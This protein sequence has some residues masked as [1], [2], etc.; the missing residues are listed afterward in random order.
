ML[1]EGVSKH[2]IVTGGTRGIGFSIASA[3][4]SDGYTVLATGVSEAEVEACNAPDGVATAVLDVTDG[5][6]VSALVD[7]CPRIDALV[8]CAGVILREGREFDPDA[9]AKV[10]DINLT[11]TMRMCVAAKD[12]LTAAAA[13]HGIAAIV[14]TASMLSFFGSAFVP[15]YSASKG[16]VA[17]LTKSLAN[18]WAQD[19]I[20]VNAIAPGWIAT[21]MTQALVEDDARSAGLIGRTPMGR[22]GRPDDMAG[23]VL[24]LCSENAAF[25]TGAVIPIDGGYL[26][27]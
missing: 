2:V 18:A 27:A 6:Q 12:K 19:G 10:I 20:R 3:F 9:F 25:V 14:N 21:D 23:T 7:A 8:N 24:H 26:S 11:G 4:A 1:N 13:E 5:A 15:A 16:G 17:Q 22:W